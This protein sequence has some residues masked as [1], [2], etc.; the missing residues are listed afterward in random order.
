MHRYSEKLATLDPAFEPKARAVIADMIALGWHIRVEWGRRTK[1]ENDALGGNA[2]KNSL[3]LTGRALDILDERILY[4]IA[5]GDKYA[6]D[7][8][9]IAKK[10]GLR[11]GGSFM[12]RWDPTHV[13][14][15]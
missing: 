11:W 10:H 6:V 14:M 5:P 3:H 2:S 7:L 8:A 1:A 9:G 4:N 12:G 15:P 13:D